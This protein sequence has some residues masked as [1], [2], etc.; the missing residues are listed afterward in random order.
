MEHLLFHWDDIVDLL[1][2]ELIEEEVKER[3]SIEKL[4]NGE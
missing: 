2:D 3:N 4:L 1:V